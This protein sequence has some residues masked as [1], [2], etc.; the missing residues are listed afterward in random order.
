LSSKG[1]ENKMTF[2]V[3]RRFAFA[4]AVA[5]AVIASLAARALA[6]QRQAV[7]SNVGSPQTAPAAP[8]AVNGPEFPGGLES[9]GSPDPFNG[10]IDRSLSRGG[11]KATTSKA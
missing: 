1:G 2:R 5:S 8:G 10:T 11:G 4:L 7:L 6:E 3:I 9:E